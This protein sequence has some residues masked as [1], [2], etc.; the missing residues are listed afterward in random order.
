M[1]YEFEKAALKK[2]KEAS[3]PPKPKARMGRPPKPKPPEPI[4]EVVTQAEG[5]DKAAKQLGAFRVELSRNGRPLKAKPELIK[6]ICDTIAKGMTIDKSCILHGVHRSMLD[7]WKKANSGILHLFEEAELK[8]E[9]E[10]VD[11]IRAAAPGDWKAA[12]WLLE[13]RHSWEQRTRAE[14]TGKDGAA[15][16]AVT[17]HQQ[18]L[19]SV[20]G[21]GDKETKKPKTAQEAIAV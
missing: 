17:I 6:A 15:L 11:I 5:L 1:L 13:R 10:L 8:S 4:V 3:L 7:K 9:N 20:A 12:N 14:L 21:S 2:E 19:A 18:L 16:A